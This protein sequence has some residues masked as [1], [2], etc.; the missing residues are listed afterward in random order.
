MPCPEGLPSLPSAGLQPWRRPL[1]NIRNPRKISRMFFHFVVFFVLF[2]RACSGC[3]FGRH[4]SCFSSYF[5]P[6]FREKPSISYIILQSMKIMNSLLFRL[7]PG[8][9]DFASCFAM[10]SKGDFS[11][12]RG[13]K[14]CF[15]IGFLTFA[16][17]KPEKPEFGEELRKSISG[18]FLAFKTDHIFAFSAP[19]SVLCPKKSRNLRAEFWRNSGHFDFY[20][21]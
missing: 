19:F 17:E 10:F 2:F 11:G 13:A 20:R 1:P 3:R 16:S 8:S 5:W 14:L 12:F 18:L 4:F 7:A 9:C 15:Y 21:F 6:L